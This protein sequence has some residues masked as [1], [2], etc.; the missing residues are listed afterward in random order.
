M[1]HTPGPWRVCKRASCWAIQ[2]I[3]GAAPGNHN[4]VVYVATP[5]PGDPTAG[6]VTSQGRTKEE[7][8]ANA[9]LI[10]ASPEL[11]ETLDNCQQVMDAAAGQI[12]SGEYIDPAELQAVAD[13]LAEYAMHARAA[14]AKARS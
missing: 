5:Y 10:A 9:R 7:C 8:E 13:Q 6:S 3:T 14:I 1:K 2:P 11:L 12:S 4:D